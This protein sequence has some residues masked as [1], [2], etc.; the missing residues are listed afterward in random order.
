MPEAWAQAGYGRVRLIGDSTNVS[1]PCPSDPDVRAAFWSAYYDDEVAKVP[2]LSPSHSL[3]SLSLLSPS[4]FLFSPLYVPLFVSVAS[5]CF[6]H[7]CLT[8]LDDVITACCIPQPLSLQHTYTPT[9]L[10]LFI[11]QSPGGAIIFPGLPFPGKLPDYDLMVEC[12][13]LSFLEEND[14]VMLDKGFPIAD[15]LFLLH[16]GLWMPVFR[17]R[18]EAQL[19]E[20]HAKW[21]KSIAN[22]RIHVERAMS[23]IK[24]WHVLCT[25]LFPDQLDLLSHIV[26]VV[27]MLSNLLPPLTDTDTRRANMDTDEQVVEPEL[28]AREEM[29]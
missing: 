12:G 21:G 5:L 19:S 16:C 10:Q 29:A 17:E 15:L 4:A 1:V 2:T 22:K 24:D 25:P 27:C 3:A 6:F 18:G 13:V 11:G 26:Y 23:R 9:H 20:A 8:C 14:D 28:S 7:F